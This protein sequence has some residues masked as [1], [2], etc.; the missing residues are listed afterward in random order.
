MLAWLS[1]NG[2][3]CQFSDICRGRFIEIDKFLASPPDLQTLYWRLSR[4][5]P[6]RDF[7]PRL[8]PTGGESTNVNPPAW[9]PRLKMP[10]DLRRYTYWATVWIRINC[11][12]SLLEY[13]ENLKHVKATQFMNAHIPIIR[14]L[15]SLD[16]PSDECINI[17][18]VCSLYQR[19]GKS[20]F[21]EDRNLI[22]IQTTRIQLRLYPL[23]ILEKRYPDLIWRPNDITSANIG[24][25]KD[26]GYWIE[27]KD[28]FLIA[29]LSIMVQ[30]KELHKVEEDMKVRD[31]LWFYHCCFLDTV[32]IYAA[33]GGP[34]GPS[35]HL[36]FPYDSR[37]FTAYDLPEAFHVFSSIPLWGEQLI[38][39]FPL[40]KFIQKSLPFAGA[41]RTLI[42][43]T[44]KNITSNDTFWKLFSSLFYCM[45]ID[46]YPEHISR[47]RNRCFDLQRL[48]A[49]TQL[50]GNR[51]ALK[52]TLA[53]KSFKNSANADTFNKEND[54]G[55]YIVFTAFRLWLLML[56]DC[57]DHYKQA[58][59]NCL[60]WNIFTNETVSM[61]TTIRN[62]S[63]YNIKDVF[64]KPR[65][66]LKGAKTVVYRYR[67]SNVVDTVLDNMMEGLEKQLFK[68][69]DEWETGGESGAAAGAA[70]GEPPPLG[71]PTQSK[72]ISQ[73]VVSSL[74]YEIP[75]TIKTNVLNLLIHVPKSKWIDPL[76]LSIMRMPDYGGITEIPIILILKLI[77]IYFNNSAKPKDFE[78][79]IS[80]FDTG[81]E[82][83]IVS[84][85]FHVLH[86]L[87]GVDFE[88]LLEKQTAQIDMAMMTT[89]YVLY[90]G[91]VLPMT[92]Y[93]VFFTICCGKIKTLFGSNAYG[94]EDIAYDST[95]RVYICAKS[96]KK[97][98][99]YNSDDFA[100][101]EFDRVK[102]QVRKQRKDFN[103]MPCQNN[104]VLC[105]DLRGF[106]LIWGRDE[107]YMH[108]PECAAFHKYE[109]T[110][111]KGSDY[112]CPVC[113]LKER[114]FHCTC[115][116]CGMPATTNGT[117]E[118]PLSVNGTG[119]IFQ[120]VYYCKKHVRK[121]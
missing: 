103:F 43:E 5:Y 88:L 104:P 87:D 11:T 23:Q 120:N 21:D 45:L 50:V 77:D 38:P 48:L 19:L 56:V 114:S 67:K 61:A 63:D 42:N 31:H 13:I 110:G 82:F 99:L 2:E 118:E 25:I 47:N 53:R 32:S 111:W 66:I 94:H 35:G 84:W 91:Q 8:D 58:I 27:T 65:D 92:A 95:R 24:K 75:P 101:S 3:L 34:S 52:E 14:Y 78:H 46:T 12:S 62:D 105:I 89:R 115:H 36:M 113:R 85:F 119:D 39:T 37:C 20:R 49:I 10:C 74:K 76:T 83:K 97:A 102:K 90:P 59:K 55:C 33:N 17:Q 108:C 106:M 71:I 69:L 41:R 44:D 68:E 60:D 116:I 51:E 93:N 80:L 16:D 107:R 30:C 18:L 121:Q 64:V 26:A 73:L 112:K 4:K 86:I 96:H 6:K 70:A 54:K 72:F 98:V 117:I 40:G 22:K 28:H 79:I 29:C 81:V 1:G 9:T 7:N 100:F 57:Q 15:D 109:W